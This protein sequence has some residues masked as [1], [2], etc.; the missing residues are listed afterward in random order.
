MSGRMRYAIYYAPAPDTPVWAFG[1]MVLGYDAAS[2]LDVP[3]FA[4]SGWS[5]EA[6]RTLTQRPRVYG[7]HATLKAPFALADG[8]G[9]GELSAAL[10]RFAAGRRPVRLG[11]MAVTAIAEPGAEHGFAALVPMS[12]PADLRA[13]E[14]DV[15][16]GFDPFRRPLD[17]D[18]RRRRRPE[19]LS[20]RQ[21]G[22]LE[23]F[24]YPHVLDDF[25]FHMTLSGATDRA[26]DAA[27]R[28][29]DAMA[30]R[31]GTV[32]LTLDSLCLFRQTGPGAPFRIVSRHAFG[33]SV[34][35]PS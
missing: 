35:Q 16:T 13:L 20:E 14:R 25:R 1:S 4:P 26:A 24:G 23:T 12:H 11:P 5:P 30:A 29:A 21:R 3:G 10:D 8:G 19:R 32:D 22:H 31:I 18:D 6:W 33:G 34:T 17:E 15:V 28:L 9:E 27:D 7:F 2:G